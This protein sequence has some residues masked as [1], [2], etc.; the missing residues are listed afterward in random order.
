MKQNNK[1]TIVSTA[2]MGHG[3]FEAK[4]KPLVLMTEIEKVVVVRKD[5]GP[6]IDK[7][8][9]KVLPKICKS[10]IF[11]LLLTPLI[12]SREVRKQ[13]ADFI[14]AYHYQ[15]HFY[16]AYF[17]S[18]FTRKPFI[19]GQTGT[20][21]QSTIDK[22]MI[23]SFLK[24]V[25]KRAKFFN[26][27]GQATFNF[28][29]SKGISKEKLNI[30]HSTVDVDIFK[31]ENVKKNYDIIFVGR[32]AEVKRLDK[33]IKAIENIVVN[34]P[35]IKICI[36]GSGPLEKCLKAQVEESGLTNNFNF[37]GL[38]NNI[39]EWLNKA[40]IFVMTSD[41]EGLPTAMMEA[42]SC[43]LLCLGSNVNNMAD[44]LK[45]GETGYL[46]KT[47]NIE[48]LSSKLKYLIDNKD[49]LNNVRINARDLIIN[50]HSYEYAQKLWLRELDAILN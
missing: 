13:K 30:L 43:G 33:L 4:F 37:V 9:Y 49:N 36:V 39:Y 29:I 2:R 47:D 11:N 38:Q 40:S 32:L 41:S 5:K 44:L 16:F 12:L 17:A 42:M 8:S 25:L 3:T 1:I 18:L 46:F 31:P 19:V 20:D 10:K 15:P 14:L 22:P 21:V 50:E 48:E 45:E 34:H 28:W 35:N 7:L 27:P 23:G 24:H 6:E 26:V